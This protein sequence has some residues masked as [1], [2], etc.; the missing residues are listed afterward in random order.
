MRP[1]LFGRLPMPITHVAVSPSD[2][3]HTRR[4]RRKVVV[5]TSALGAGLLG[6]GLSARPG[7]RSFYGLTLTVAATWTVGGL[8]SGPLHLGWIRTRDHSLRRPVLTPLATGAAAFAGFY[9]AALVVRRIPFL[10]D[11]VARVLRFADEGD[12]ALVV[13]TTC[14]N[15]VAEEVFFRGALFA[16]IPERYAVAGSTAV[17]TLATATT[18]NPALVLAAAAMGTLLGLQ[19]RASG[20]VQAPLL[21]HLTWSVLMLRFL[22]P[23]FRRS[24]PSPGTA[25][26]RA[27]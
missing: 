1:D 18:R 16:A 12:V 27:R 11:A 25:G 17:Y 20:G 3:E 2:G 23:L 26:S 5:L 15:G 24:D 21:T 22:P 6:A 13:L 14:A 4:R 8:L 19:R 7:S 10:Y 9:G